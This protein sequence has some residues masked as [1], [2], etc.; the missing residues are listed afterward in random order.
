[1][2]VNYPERSPHVTQFGFDMLFGVCRPVQ[3][4]EPV[5]AGE[6]IVRAESK[7]DFKAV[8]GQV[9]S[10]DLVQARARIGGTM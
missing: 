5:L 7:T 2:L 8:F 4:R 9:E 3:F 1:M 10:R 6:F